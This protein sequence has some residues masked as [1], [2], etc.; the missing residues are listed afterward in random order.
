MPLVRPRFSRPSLRS[1]ALIAAVGVVAAS[2]CYLGDTGLP[3][4]HDKPYFPTGVVV[5]PGRTTLY[6]V[7]SDF[8]LQ[9]NGGTVQAFDLGGVRSTKLFPLL[10]GLRAGSAT[11]C[12]DVGLVEN[13]NQIL[14][15]GP[16]TSVT[17]LVY[18]KLLKSFA[19]IGAFASGALLVQNP[20]GI[21]ARLFV[22]VRGD[23]S[24]TWFSVR[25]DSDGVPC[26]G[27][28]GAPAIDR[29][30]DC[31][32][33]G[34][35]QRCSDRH[36]IGVDPYDN[37]RNLT[38]P[39]EP[40]GIAVSDDTEAL[41]VAHQTETAV[42]VSVNPWDDLP[43]LEFA[44]YN[45][46]DGP[47]EVASVPTPKLVTASKGAGAG[48]EIVYQPGF[49]VT[50]RN[51]PQLDL[52]RY[53]ADPLGKP[54]RPFVTRVSQTPITVIADGK[55]SRGI[56]V[57][58]SARQACEA[59]CAD[60]DLLCLRTCVATPVRVFIANRMPPSLLI[61]NLYT[62]I[63]DGDI[64][65]VNGSGAFDRVEI[66]GS[67]P[68]T[69]GASKVGIGNVIDPL[70]NPAMRVFAVSFDSRF[71]FSYDPEAHVVDA[72]IRTG[73]GPHAIAFDAG[74]ERLSDGAAETG[75]SF[76]YVA[77]FTD[78]YLG[79]V[80]LDMRHPETFGTMFASIGSPTPPRESK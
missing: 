60:G 39:I 37:L 16:C 15:P 23:P 43:K 22:P 27:S 77:H 49:L 57:D 38:L 69:V 70:G 58:P 4:P 79:V 75:Y 40:V 74:S 55:D 47:T 56:A 17:P 35:E 45:L 31:A 78:S 25:D 5:S 62:D 24:I 29:C 42:S 72:V 8:D 13:D 53:Y 7:N 10:A 34:E 36:R 76:L 1:K 2:G 32:A 12:A 11:A 19:G 3:P 68:L 41:L 61:A 63:V 28:A 18:P 14:N 44:L 67:V 33:S 80:D 73:R 71:V 66:V 59:T 54:P 51:A 65:G 9:Y 64:S 48:E 6:V 46:G 52:M 20:A 26:D 30:L 50:Y 21:G